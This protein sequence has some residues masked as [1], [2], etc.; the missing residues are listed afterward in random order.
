MSNKRSDYI[1]M[2]TYLRLPIPS[3]AKHRACLFLERLGY[4]FCVDFGTE[5]AV[6]LAREA[7]A[8]WGRIRVWETPHE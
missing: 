6:E 7:R 5:N 1:R 8:N 4:R 2:I 3:L